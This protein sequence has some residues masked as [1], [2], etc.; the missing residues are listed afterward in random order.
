M[1]GIAGIDDEPRYHKVSGTSLDFEPPGLHYQTPF[2]M[3]F[4]HIGTDEL[5]DFQCPVRFVLA[6]LDLWIGEEMSEDGIVRKTESTKTVLFWS[7]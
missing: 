2:Q 7:L 6:I 1:V 5:K 3:I 4:A